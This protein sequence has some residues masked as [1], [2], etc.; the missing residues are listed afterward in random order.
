MIGFAYESDEQL[1]EK[2]ADYMQSSFEDLPWDKEI[3]YIEAELER[4]GITKDNIKEKFP[5]YFI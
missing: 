5:E 2:L 1:A 3:S 4:R